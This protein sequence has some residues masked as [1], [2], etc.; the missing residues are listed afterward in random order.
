MT[1]PSLVLCVYGDGG[2]GKSTLASTAPSPIF[3]DSEEG[4]KA[5]KARGINVPF[6]AI[7][8]WANVREAWSLIS[9]SDE[10]KTVVIDPMDVFMSLL[11]EDLSGSGTMTLQKWGIAKTQMRK[12]I[13]A[14]KSSGKHVVFVA[15][16]AETQDEDK[17]IRSPR[18][19]ANLSK[20][21]TDLCDV[22]GYLRVGEGNIR[23]MI[24][25]PMEKY[26]AKDRYDAFGKILKNPNV[27]DMIETIHKKYEDAPFEESKSS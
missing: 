9:K 24:V 11:I 2:V 23:E 25:Q 8:S 5:F 26:K 27:T 19:A 16:E 13:W 1:K 3:L 10:Y 6:I 18:I 4:V 7:K 21:L 14:V 15:H 20:E 12:F 22:V 17:L